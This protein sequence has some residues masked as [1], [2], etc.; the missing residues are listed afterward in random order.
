IKGFIVDRIIFFE[1]GNIRSQKEVLLEKQGRRCLH[2]GSI[3][4]N[5]FPSFGDVT[6]QFISH[7]I[8]FANRKRI[9]GHPCSFSGE[10]KELNLLINELMANTSTSLIEVLANPIAIL[11]FE[12]FNCGLATDGKER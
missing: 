7:Q 6:L 12:D 11:T 5:E 9:C 1:L 3:G 4:H 2:K 10:R 8:V